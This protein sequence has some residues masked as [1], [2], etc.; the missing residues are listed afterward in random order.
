MTI[1]TMIARQSD[2]LML[3][4][5]MTDKDSRNLDLESYRQQAKKLFKAIDP[6]SGNR[7]TI[8]SGPYYFCYLV[9]NEVIFLTLC[10][11]SFPKKL[12]MRF[13]EEL[14]KEFDI[15]YGSEVSSAKRPY[16]F[17]KFDAFIEKTKKVYT[18]NRSQQ[19]LNKVTE[20]LSDVQKIMARNINEILHRGDKID[21]VTKKSDDLLAGTVKYAKL[22][23]DLNASFWL[24]KEGLIG[25]AI[26]LFVLIVYY[27]FFW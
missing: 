25:I 3:A 2:G 11:K 22:A 10:D 16:T 19:N 20:D 12:A 1:T 7:M 21:S 5:S 6:R 17:V 18:D 14:Q 15:Q 23:K 24:R 13:L 27:K 8:E 26:V 9:E 4:E